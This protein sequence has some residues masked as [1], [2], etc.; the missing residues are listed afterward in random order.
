[1]TLTAEEFI[2]RFSQHILPKGFT[3]IRM[4]GYLSNR[5]R[6]G[7]IKAVLK[8]LKLPQHPV[9]V[10]VPFALRILERYG[11]EV[12]RCPCCGANTLELLLVYMPWKKVDDG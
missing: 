11:V 7:R 5:G 6:Q 2:R 10:R 9:V 1:M 8:T 3:K 12:A 4:Y